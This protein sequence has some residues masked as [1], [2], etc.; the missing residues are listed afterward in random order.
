[1]GLLIFLLILVLLGIAGAICWFIF[2][3]QRDDLLEKLDLP[4][5]REK[6]AEF[7]QVIKGKVT[8]WTKLVIKH[9]KKLINKLLKKDFSEDESNDSDGY[10][11]DIGNSPDLPQPESFPDLT[12]SMDS[13]VSLDSSYDPADETEYEIDPEPEVMFESDIELEDENPPE[14]ESE[15][16]SVPEIDFT[17]I[18]T[19]DGSTPYVPP[20]IRKDTPALPQYNKDDVSEIEQKNI[21]IT[22]QDDT[23]NVT[24]KD[25]P[26]NGE[27]SFRSMPVGIIEYD[28]DRFPFEDMPPIVPSPEAPKPE[29]VTAAYDSIIQNWKKIS[30]YEGDNAPGSPKRVK[31]KVKIRLKNK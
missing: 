8:D 3:D 26:K 21:K 18:L 5:K 25:R 31:V 14:F 9:I 10:G 1:M 23:K 20:V 11:Y 2:P 4:D 24:P 28:S 19:F 16:E 15:F 27:D 17:P 6:L 29:A 22:S 30:N 12:L 13:M 7:F